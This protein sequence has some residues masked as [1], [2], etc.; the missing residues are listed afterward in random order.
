M[1]NDSDLKRQL[2]FVLKGTNFDFLGEKY[3]GK[4]RDSY[5]A[6][7]V[8][9]LITSDRISCFDVVVTTVP[10]KGQVLNEMAVWWFE[11]TKGVIAN[12]IIDVPDLN[13]MVARNVEIL[14]IEVIVRGYITG[15]AWRDYQDGK[16]ISGI[17]LPT[18]LRASQKLPEAILTP[19]T[20][21]AI[22]SHD[23]PISE[24]EILATGV[25]PAALWGQVKESALELFRLGQEHAKQQG[26]I[27]V[28]TKYEFGLL[29]GKLVLADEIHTL[30]SSRFWIAESY[31][32]RFEKGEAP[33]MLDKEP[34]RQW[35]LSQGFKGDGPVPTFTDEHRVEIS[36][37]YINSF[38]RII[39]EEF[40]GEVGSASE[41][42]AGRLREY[43][44]RQ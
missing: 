10:F 43:A 24:Q 39:G 40:N 42:I 25:V 2:P 17:T 12:H 5:L 13:V 32:G 21:A 8:R 41:R 26:L 38:E 11:K 35:L 34:T 1:L 4:V 37:H 16:A 20:K 28:D 15:S 19:S 44:G 33:E 23:E 7:D 22:G 3:Q 14:P 31:Q 27:L 6:G 9:Y 29:N 18:G 36:R 30:D